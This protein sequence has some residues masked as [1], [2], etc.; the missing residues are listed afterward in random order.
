MSWG[1]GQHPTDQVTKVSAV[2][3]VY[4]R[5]PPLRYAAGEAVE[6]VHFREIAMGCASV[7]QKGEYAWRGG[8]VRL[9]K[10]SGAYPLRR[11]AAPP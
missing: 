1:R 2:L 3:D 7:C 6:T 4:R 9:D 8:V 11:L 10:K 5:V